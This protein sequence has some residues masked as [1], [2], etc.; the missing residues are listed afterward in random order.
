MHGCRVSVEHYVQCCYDFIGELSY[1][2]FNGFMGKFSAILSAAVTILLSYLSE[3]LCVIMQF[4]NLLVRTDNRSNFDRK[5]C[6]QEAQI[7]SY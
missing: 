4:D 6:S 3:N 5:V 1:N 7:F 2:G